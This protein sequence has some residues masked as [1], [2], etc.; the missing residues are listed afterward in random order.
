MLSEGTAGER[1]KDVNSRCLFSLSETLQWLSGIETSCFC[2]FG[3]SLSLVGGNGNF[4]LGSPPSFTINL[5]RL[6]GAHPFW[7]LEVGQFPLPGQ[8]VYYTP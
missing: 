8:S 1:N 4:P 7:S 3:I 5:C 2:L 6:R